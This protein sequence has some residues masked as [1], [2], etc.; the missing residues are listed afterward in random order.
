LGAKGLANIPDEQKFQTAVLAI[1]AGLAAARKG[2]FEKALNTFSRSIES[3]PDRWESYRFRGI[4]HVK[5]GQHDLAIADLGAAIQRNPE[6]AE[7]FYERATAKML[8]GQP[9]TA[10]EDLSRCLSLNAHFAPAYSTRAGIY[11]RMG[12]YRQALED[13]DVA[14]KLKR[15]NAGY[16]HNRAVILTAMDRW[17]EAVENYEQAIKLDPSGGGTYNN[18]AWLHATAK[19]PAFRNC[20]KAVF[21]CRKALEIGKNASWLDTLA[22]AYAECGDFEKAL[23]IATQAYRL[24]R[25]PN[26][27]FRQRIE[28]YRL[29]KTYSDWRAEN[30]KN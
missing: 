24:S 6:C 9:R 25:P 22:A 10:L 19:D 15:G 18:L 8:A 1:E 2:Q 14:V 29:G 28:I 13:I 27:N 17:G 12:L 7:C 16:L 26:E 4:T 30:S 3:D 11:T 21:Y 23:E 5:L 20:R